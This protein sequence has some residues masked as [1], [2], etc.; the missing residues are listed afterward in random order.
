M[1][2]APLRC[3]IKDLD[4][5]RKDDGGTCMVKSCGELFTWV[6]EVEKLPIVSLISSSIYWLPLVFNGSKFVA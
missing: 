4:A 6:D 1:D 2:N 5:P 3:A